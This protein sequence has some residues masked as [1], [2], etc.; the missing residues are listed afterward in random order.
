MVP[1][2]IT[3]PNTGKITFG[4]ATANPTLSFYD[5]RIA[6]VSNTWGYSIAFTY[7]TDTWVA[8]GGT[9]HI[10]TRSDFYNTVVSPSIQA[11]VTYAFPFSGTTDMTDMAGNVWR[12]T[13]TSIQRPGDT[14][15]YFTVTRDSGTGI[16]SSVTNDGVTMS[17]SL[18]MV[19]NTGT[20]TKTNAL[21]QSTVITS[22]LALSLP[23]SIKDGLNRTT[24]Y[25]YDT[26]GRLT[27]VTQPEGNYVQYTLDARGNATQT[28][29]VAKSGTGLPPIVTS[30]VYSSTCTNVLTCNQPTSTTDARG[31]TTDYTYDSTTGGILTVTRPA[32]TTGGTRPQTRYSYTQ[33]G[34]GMTSYWLPTGISECQTTASCTG[35]TDEVKTTIGYDGNANPTTVS[36]GDGAGALTATNTMTYD[37]M[38][39]MLTVDGPLSGTSDT[40]KFQ[41]DLARRQIGKMSPDP[42]GAGPLKNREIRTTY[43]SAGRA[44]RREVGTVNSDWT[45]FVTAETVDVTFFG[46]RI[47]TQKLSAAGSDYA[48]T[49][50]SYDAAGRP[51]CK[52]VRMN[53]AVYGSLPA[54]ACTLSTQGSD[55][56][57]RISQTVYDAASEPTQLKVAVGTADAATELTL[58]YTT[59]GQ[60]QTLKDAENNLTTYAYDGQ[61]RLSQTQYPTPTPKGAGTSNASDFEQITYENTASNTRTSGTVASRRLRDGT[62]I[63]FTYDNLTRLTLKTLP[64]S[65]PAVSYAYDNLDRPTSA[66]QTGNGVSTSW[67]ALS[68]KTAETGPQGTTS[69]AYDLAGERVGITYSTSGGGSALTVNYAYLTTG[70]LSTISQSGTTLATYGYDNLGNRTSASFANGASQAFT[71][72]PVSRLATLTNTLTDGNNLTVDN[73]AYNAA[74][75]MKAI[76]R[77]GDPYIFTPYGSGTTAYTQNGLNQQVTIGGTSASWDARGNLTSEPQSGKTYGYSSENLLTSASGGVTMAY[78]PATRLYQVA[79]GATTRFAYDG[80]DVIAEYDGT[81]TLLRRFVFDPTNSQPILWYEGAGVA[82]ANRRYL[83]HDEHGSVIS[84][85]DSS[86]AKIYINAYDEYGRPQSTNGGRFQYTGQKWIAEAGLYDY[87]ARDYLPHLGIFAQTDPAGYDASPNLYAYVGGEPINLFDPF[88]MTD[89][90]TW[91]GSH[92]RRCDPN[93]LDN[94][95]IEAGGIPIW[96]VPVQAAGVSEGDGGGGADPF[97]PAQKACGR[98]DVDACLGLTPATWNPTSHDYTVGPFDVCSGAACTEAIRDV[99]P[100]YVVPNLG[101]PVSDQ[102]ISPVYLFPDAPLI[103]GHVQTVFYDDGFSARNITQSDHWLCCGTVDIINWSTPTGWQVAAYGTG[104]NYFG[105]GWANQAF[106]PQIFKALLGSYIAAVRARAIV[107]G[108]Y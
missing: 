26:S 58:T 42:D 89:C 33:F 83:G 29:A 53:T 47:A 96:S 30:A 62:S 8:P 60:R 22:N 63:A 90:P 71:Y 17:Y 70:E 95:I 103:I 78:D 73:V 104:T 65:E 24:S 19:G 32:P 74:S 1:D 108:A 49:Q 36:K 100:S 40:T 56:P 6:S 76:R 82:A 68:R 31:N 35:T 41:Y 43:D 4:W 92:I 86:G 46:M 23:T 10:K 75:Q 93:S 21:S 79:G 97:T 7:Q 102:Q 106:G 59:N 39:N 12:L 101:Q 50:F 16:V 28:Q 14:S 88:G 72:D 87:K 27:Q 51:D 69:F 2:R 52:A 81:N 11:S 67:D 9:W 64:N 18:S 48:L 25:A 77:T 105:V 38:G 85:S 44:T 98:G 55:G 13:D 99:F 84:I 34:T 57:D 54:S 20:M 66:S 107:T 5:Y 45:G 15:P 80:A 91:V 3:F 94:A 61:D 37:A